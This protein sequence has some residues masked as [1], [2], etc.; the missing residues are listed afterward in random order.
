MAPKQHHEHSTGGGHTT[1]VL[2]NGGLNGGATDHGT[3]TVVAT[4]GSAASAPAV[5]LGRCRALFNYTPKLYDELELQPGDILEVHIKQEDGWWL[6]ALRGQIGIFPATY[7]E[8][9]P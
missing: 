9:I 8:E 6:G 1:T 7:V 5:I 2:I 4:N 3:D